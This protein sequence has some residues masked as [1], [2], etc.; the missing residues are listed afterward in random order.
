MDPFKESN[1]I[2]FKRYGVPQIEVLEV[3]LLLYHNSFTQQKLTN[4]Y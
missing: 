1:I 4:I 3:R 2:W